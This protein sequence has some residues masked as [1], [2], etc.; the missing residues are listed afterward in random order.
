MSLQIKS[1]QVEEAANE[2]INM[3]MIEE[4]EEKDEEEEEKE[5]AEESKKM[6]KDEICFIRNYS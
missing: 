3:L 2:V 4:E 6:E 1:T 5:V